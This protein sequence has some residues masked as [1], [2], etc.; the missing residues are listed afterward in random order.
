MQKYWKIVPEKR[1][2]CVEKWRFILIFISFYFIF[3]FVTRGTVRQIG[4][5]AKIMDSTGLWWVD[6]WVTGGS[7][8]E[9]PEIVQANGYYYLF[10]AAGKYCQPSYSEGVAV[11]FC[12]TNDGFWF[13]NDGFW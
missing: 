4:A 1:W 9:G 11:R 12:I 3:I 2:F 5:P 7:L 8:V 6:S 10:F 13:T